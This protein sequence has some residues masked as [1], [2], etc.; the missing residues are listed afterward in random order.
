MQNAASAS[1]LPQRPTADRAALRHADVVLQVDGAVSGIHG[2]A[3]LTAQRD[4]ATGLRA[5]AL[6]RQ[7]AAEGW[8]RAQLARASLALLRPRRAEVKALG[9]AY[10]AS[11]TPGVIE[12]AHR[13]RRAGVAVELAGEVAVEA[14][15]GV[16][17][18]LGVTPDAIHA[19]R[20]R[21]D[22]LGAYTGCEVS[23]EMMPIAHGYTSGRTRRVYVGTGAPEQKAAGADHFVRF[24]GVVAHEGPNRGEHVESFADLADL[25]TG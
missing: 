25:V 11:L 14:M 6:R 1:D 24:T 13:M 20:I 15:L 4:Q 21:F 16:A 7:A 19:P 17:G 2:L 3:W 23:D 18:A 10:L 8:S 22:A 9:A 5:E 12:A